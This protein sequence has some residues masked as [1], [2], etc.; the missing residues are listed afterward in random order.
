MKGI[1]LVDDEMLIRAKLKKYL[2]DSDFIFEN[3]YEASNG[4]DAL[5]IL[6]N[7]VAE[8]AIVDI[9][10]PV[11]NGIEFLKNICDAKI[12]TK[13]IFLTGFEKF[14]YAKQAIKY[15]A[16]DYLLKPI[17]KDEL[18]SALK[19]ISENF[20]IESTTANSN[21]SQVKNAHFTVNKVIEFINL[22]YS[23]KDLNLNYLAKEFVV[24]SSYLS[25]IFKK[26]TE[27]T[28]SEYITE[29]RIE[30]AKTLIKCNEIKI[31]EIYEKV[32][33]NDYYYFSKIFK[34]YTGTSPLK[35]RQ[36]SNIDNAFN[37]NS[38]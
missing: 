31:S 6:K 34:K 23:N 20:K 17:N 10:M 16:S 12:D 2:I 3:I 9:N 26:S 30:Q 22:N 37:K 32:G 29:K 13:I 8:L 19:N 7:N 1:L 25:H 27:K 24:N 28:L 21:V 36:L 18:Y 4:L 5:N 38:L 14:E 11:M 15:N 33:Y 35:Y